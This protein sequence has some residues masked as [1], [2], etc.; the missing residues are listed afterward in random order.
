MEGLLKHRQA[1]AMLGVHINTLY[2][3]RAAGELPRGAVCR[4][5]GIYFYDIKKI[6][7]SAVVR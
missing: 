4:I 1:A 5:G 6:M 7:Q 2:R 3:W